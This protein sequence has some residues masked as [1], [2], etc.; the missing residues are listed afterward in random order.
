MGLKERKMAFS[1]QDVEELSARGPGWL[2]ERR[3]Q[4]WDFFEKLE[5]PREKDEPWRYT[6]LPRL[7]FELDAF[8]PV[9]PPREG[10]DGPRMIDLPEGRSGLAVISAGQ[11]AQRALDPALEAQG[12]VLTD[13]A[14]ALAEHADLLEP[15]LLADGHAGDNIFSALHGALAWG[16]TFLYVP[17]GLTVPLPIESVQRT[18][19]AAGAAFPHTVVVVEDDAEI[20]FLERF[21][22]PDGD[23]VLVDG[24][25]DLFAGARARV[26]LVALQEHGNQAWHF[27]AQRATTG[28]EATLQSL[29]VTLGGRFSRSVVETALRGE[30]GSI[31]MLGLYFADEGQHFDFRTLQDHVAPASTSDLLYKGALKDHSRTVYSGLI[32]VNEGAWKTDAYQA[33]RNLVLSDEAKADSKP[34]LEILNNDVRCT[35]G[36]TV[37]QIDDEELF[38]LQARGIS[39]QEAERLIVKGFFEDVIGRLSNAELRGLLEEAIERKLE[40]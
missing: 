35:H 4:A 8:S 24:V 25:L 29:V 18:A 14:T 2:G 6:D 17:K 16:G 1:R 27:H 11:A 31:E 38:Y 28:P 13:L 22:S 23:A 33:N 5:L 9:V 32:R 19:V 30:H 7:G 10:Q 36:S 12:V 3:I 37:G 15:R 20:V 39:R 21:D 40:A 34:E 26:R